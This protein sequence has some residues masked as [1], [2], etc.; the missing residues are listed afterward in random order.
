MLELE[1]DILIPAA[2]EQVITTDNM[3]N[4]KCKVIAEA[5]N[6]PVSYDASSYLSKE[7]I[8]ILPDFYLNAGIF[9]LQFFCF[10]FFLFF[11]I[12]FFF[13]FCFAHF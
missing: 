2:L 9:E 5:A 10:S 11:F 1:C 4:I 8:M 3:R 12:F 6:G 13:A 7:G